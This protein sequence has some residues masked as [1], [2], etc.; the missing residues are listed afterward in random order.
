MGTPYVKNEEK[1]T[2]SFKIGDGKYDYYGVL[3]ENR[4]G[5]DFYYLEESDEFIEKLKKEFWDNNTSR[6]DNLQYIPKCLGDITSLKR[7]GKS[8]LMNLR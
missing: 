1:Y 3:V 2:I 8:G 4:N 7:G 6:A 5:K